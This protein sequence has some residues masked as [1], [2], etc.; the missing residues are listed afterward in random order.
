VADH[1]HSF[2]RLSS[3][4]SALYHT[5]LLFRHSGQRGSSGM[6]APVITVPPLCFFPPRPL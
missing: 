5:L 1:D 6:Q 4:L 2:R 3:G